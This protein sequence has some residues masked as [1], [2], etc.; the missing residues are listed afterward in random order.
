M[1]YGDGE[2][3]ETKKI[4]TLSFTERN[5]TLRNINRRGVD[6]RKTHGFLKFLLFSLMEDQPRY[7]YELIQKI[8]DE[9]EGYLQPGQGTVYGALERLEGEG[10]IEEVDLDE[11]DEDSS[12]QYYGL[13]GE[14][15]EE[16]E[17]LRGKCEE[18]INPVDQILGLMYIYRFLA[19]KEEFEV[20][21]EEIGE[22]FF[23]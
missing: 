12:R 4:L 9:S 16:L 18:E 2:R 7:G 13:T 11:D 21:L 20:L 5:I 6:L 3:T 10:W 1:M 17:R 15:R 14:G 8:E 22:E 19:G 23:D